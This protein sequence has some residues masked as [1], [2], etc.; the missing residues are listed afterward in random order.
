MI[1][2]REGEFSI[3]VCQ[4]LMEAYCRDE[5]DLSGQPGSP[6][7]VTESWI[8]ITF[9][10]RKQTCLKNQQFSFFRIFLTMFLEPVL[11]KGSYG[12]WDRSRSLGTIVIW[13]MFCK[14]EYTFVRKP[15]FPDYHVFA[16]FHHAQGG[17][18]FICLRFP[19][20]TWLPVPRARGTGIHRGDDWRETQGLWGWI[21]WVYWGEEVV[22]EKVEE[23]EEKEEEK[24][25]KEADGT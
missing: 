22:E 14:S 3:H 6:D 8:C 17:K 7:F 25:E 4:F 12:P 20:R 5:T 2:W 11:W 24:E 19:F 21:C 10:Q 23:E 16:K 18:A 15:S 13:L 1:C 9:W